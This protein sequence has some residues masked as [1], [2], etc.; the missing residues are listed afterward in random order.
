MQPQTGDSSNQ[1][2]DFTTNIKVHQNQRDLIDNA[3]EA[4][5]KNCSDSTLET[6]CLFMLD[7]EKFQQ[8]MEL[9]DTPPSANPALRKM[10]T[11]KAPWE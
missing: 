3:A 5:S 9:L 4:P 8:F 10:L 11:T 1:N 2:R 6:A 7:D